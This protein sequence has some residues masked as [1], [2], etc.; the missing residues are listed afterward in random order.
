VDGL[1]LTGFADEVVTRDVMCGRPLR[2][3]GVFYV[4]RSVECSHVFGLLMQREAAGLD[5]V[6]GPAPHHVNALEAL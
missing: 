6:R 1:A 3:K 5:E 2:R 4:R